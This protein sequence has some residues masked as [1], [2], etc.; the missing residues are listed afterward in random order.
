M[1][2]SGDHPMRARTAYSIELTAEV[3]VPQWRAQP[4]PMKLEENGFFDG[5]RFEYLQ[6]R[7]TTYHLIK[8]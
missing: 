2:G 7:Q 1:P 5:V 6:P 3:D 4:L 8:P